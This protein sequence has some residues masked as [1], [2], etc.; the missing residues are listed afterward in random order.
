MENKENHFCENCGKEHDGS[1]G[2][3]RFCSKECAKGFSTKNELIKQKKANCIECGRLILINKRAS[4]KTCKC[5]YCKSKNNNICKICGGVLDKTSGVCKNDFCKKHNQQHFRSLIK[6]FGFDKNKL[7]TKEVESEFNRIRDMLFDLYW[8]KK[9]STAEISKKFNYKSSISNITKF[10]RTY[11]DIP[12]KSNKYAV[13]ENY[14]EGRKNICKTCKCK[15]KSGWHITW[16]NKKV[17]LRSSYEF[18]YAKELDSKKI[19]YDVEC[20][21]IK[22]FDSKHKEY[23]CAIPDFYIPSENMIVEIKSEYTLDKQ[24]MKDKIYEYN[25]LGYNFKLICGHKELIL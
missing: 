24:N 20:L 13:I 10:F 4:D 16:N 7:G 2:S 5:D 22:Y 6:Y 12:I 3:G 14:I 25:K 23:R 1:Y 8:N 18:D 15:Y 11:L 21:H 9:M 17:F 19:D